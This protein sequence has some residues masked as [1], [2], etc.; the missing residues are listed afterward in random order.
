MRD[1]T[2]S[3]AL[4][5]SDIPGGQQHYPNHMDRDA[6]HPDFRELDIKRN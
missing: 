2:H 6:T 1:G 5:H 4:S 3:D